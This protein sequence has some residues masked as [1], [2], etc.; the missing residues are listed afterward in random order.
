MAA[1][2]LE[3]AKNFQ[4]ELDRQLVEDATSGWMEANAGQVKYSG[5]NEIKIPRITM[6]GLGDYDRELGFT[7]GA[8]TLTYQT[9][10]LTM[11]R[12]RTFMIDA[13]DVD[14]TNF[15]VT[16]GAVMGEFPDI[17]GVIPSVGVF[18]SRGIFRESPSRSK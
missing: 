15:V 4:Q 10:T 17:G 3:Y 7:P 1:N 11:D 12:D 14:E 5:G 9:E 8:V 18:A 13:M 16:A 2:V 6:N